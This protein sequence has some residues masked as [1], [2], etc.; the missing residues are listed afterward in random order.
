MIL[1]TSFYLSNNIERNNELKK[2]LIKNYQNNYI[3]KI[4]LLNNQIYNLDFINNIEH[5]FDH[6]NTYQVNTISNE[7]LNI[8]KKIIQIIINDDINYILK[9][10]DAINFA[11]NQCENEICILSNSDIYFDNS[12]LKIKPINF[13][14]IV[15]ALLRYDEDNN[16]NKKIFERFNIPRNDSQDSW[17]FKSPLNI[18]L[19]KADFSFGTLGCDNIFA[20][21]LNQSNIILKNPAYDIISTHVHNSDYRTYEVDNRLNGKYCLIDPV[22]LNE[23]SKISYMDSKTWEIISINI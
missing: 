12:L 19:N 21:I 20:Y 11:N 4:Y 2:C 23:E 10:N 15:Y 8:N 13:N 9:Y 1:I 14:N 16:G 7:K 18:D 5:S 17:I 22:K 6:K 3:K